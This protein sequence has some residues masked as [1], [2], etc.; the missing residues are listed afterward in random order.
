MEAITCIQCCYF[1][2]LLGIKRKD[3]EIDPI[4]I[5]LTNF[6]EGLEGSRRGIENSASPYL[7]RK[8]VI[9]Q[10]SIG[11]RFLDPTFLILSLTQSQNELFPFYVSQHQCRWPTSHGRQ[12][13][14]WTF[15]LV[16]RSARS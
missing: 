11:I 9:C 2:D 16:F 12:S 8:H 6:W 5:A 4:L 7:G 1:L 14:M 10:L 15:Q 3:N 13:K